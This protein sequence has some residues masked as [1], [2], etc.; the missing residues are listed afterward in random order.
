MMG[1]SFASRAAVQKQ[2]ARRGEAVAIV[3]ISLTP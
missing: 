1:P 3:T 2:P